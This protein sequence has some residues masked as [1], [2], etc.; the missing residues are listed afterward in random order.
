MGV[1]VRASLLMKNRRAQLAI[2]FLRFKVRSFL[3][4]I[5]S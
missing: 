5:F 2:E 3:P 4:P 1:S